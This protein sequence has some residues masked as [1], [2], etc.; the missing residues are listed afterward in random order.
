MSRSSS[1]SRSVDHAVIFLTIQHSVC[2]A[3]AQMLSTCAATERVGHPEHQCRPSWTFS[4]WQS[5][6]V[7]NLDACRSKVLLHHTIWALSLNR[8]YSNLCD[9]AVLAQGSVTCSRQRTTHATH[10][11]TTPSWIA[12]ATNVP[13]AWDG[14]VV[15]RA[16]RHCQHHSPTIPTS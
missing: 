12:S 6:S 14:A 4:H 16:L 8:H 7:L 10:L 1:S 2:T 3:A 15:C 13:T 11:I 9:G 5:L